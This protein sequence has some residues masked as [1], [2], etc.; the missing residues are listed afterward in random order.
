ML[1]LHCFIA[2]LNLKTWESKISQDT[3]KF[4]HNDTEVH[5][6]L[7]GITIR[8]GVKEDDF[9]YKATLII[10]DV[11]IIDNSGT[12]HCEHK[13]KRSRDPAHVKVVGKQGRVTTYW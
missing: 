2:A 9:L 11:N 10:E 3:I 12:Y 6:T 7:N 4:F 8:E 1:E 13:S 5:G